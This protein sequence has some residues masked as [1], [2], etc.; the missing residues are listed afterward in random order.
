MSTCANCAAPLI[1]GWHFCDSCGKRIASHEIIPIECEIHKHQEAVGICIICSTPVCSSCAVDV[2]GKIVCADSHHQV[3]F[4]N[5]Q[6]VCC[7][8]SEF[9][10]EAFICN[11]T[12]AGVQ[13]QYFS[14]HDHAMTSWMKE[15]RILV[16]VM[17][18]EHKHAL[19]LL[20]ELY[21]I[22]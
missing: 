14:F 9:E 3:L 19:H 22:K 6:R 20:K 1:S 13:A 2:E 12:Q 4:R 17:K 5:W 8:D 10:A 21:L 11:L 16:F 18:S 15:N 7:L